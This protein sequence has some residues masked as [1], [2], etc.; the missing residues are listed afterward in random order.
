M[1][2]ISVILG[3]NLGLAMLPLNNLTNVIPAVMTRN[4]IARATAKA[5]VYLNESAGTKIQRVIHNSNNNNNNTF[6]KCFSTMQHAGL[7][8]ILPILLTNPNGANMKRVVT[9]RTK[10]RPVHQHSPNHPSNT[11]KW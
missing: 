3:S 2:V 1:D 6:A 11:P 10:F 7:H 9:R 8:S 5:E 4:T